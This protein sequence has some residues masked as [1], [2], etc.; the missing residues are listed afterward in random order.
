MTT[1]AKKDSYRWWPVES[2]LQL[3]DRL[4]ACTAPRLEDRNGLLRVVET[5]TNGDSLSKAADG[6]EDCPDINESHICP[7][8]CP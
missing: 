8:R 4:N 2:T 5:A 6:G 1:D 7:P 3:R